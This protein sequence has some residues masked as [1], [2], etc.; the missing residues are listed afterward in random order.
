MSADWLGRLQANPLPALL[1]SGEPSLAYFAGKDLLEE[2]AG[3]VE[4]LWEMP[5]AVALLNE[6]RTEG[7]WRYPAKSYDPFTGGNYDLLETFR[8]LRVL[9]EMYGFTRCHP[10]MDRAAGYILSC[11]TAEGDLRGILGNQ[12]MPYYHGAIL[13]L[14][15]KAGYG[16]HAGVL[17]GLEWLLSVRQEDGGWL[18]PTQLVPT[19]LRTHAY[20]VGPPAGADPSKPSSHL[21]TGMA[22]RPFAAHPAYRQNEAVQAAARL[23]KTRLFQADRYNDRKAASYWLK[24]QFPF[25]WTSLVTALDT[26]CRLGYG[27]EDGDMRRGLDWFFAHQGE[28]GLWETG[29][30]SGKGAANNRRWVGLAICRILKRVKTAL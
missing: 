29:Y 3:P 25:W 20:W 14:L 13:E 7:Y 1:L 16:D 18:V 6:Q 8:S 11:Q 4:S 19:R 23:L 26:L 27:E 9:V 5:Q 2:A 12:Y 28:D 15:V 21:A 22:L 30:G 10:A 17:R 24:F